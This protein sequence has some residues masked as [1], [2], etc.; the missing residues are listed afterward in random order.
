M[1]LLSG[2]PKIK[3]A[4]YLPSL[5]LHKNHTITN[6]I[7][8]YQIETRSAHQKLFNA[9]Q[10][11]HETRQHYLPKPGYLTPGITALEYYNRRFDLI[12]K[13]P[14]KSIAILTGNQIQYSSGSV[15]HE[16]QQDNDLYYMTGWLEP[17]SVAI[18][19]KR[20][21]NGDDEDMILHM[22]VPPRNPSVEIWEGERSG[23]QG[24]Y[25]FFNADLVEDINKIDNY[26]KE[27]IKRNHHVYW[28]DKINK[29][30]G[31]NNT[32]KFQTFFNNFSLNKIPITINEVLKSSSN[33]S[34]KPLHTLIAKQ[35][36]IKS[37]QEIKVLQKACQI[38]S[39]AINKAMAKVGSSS[40]IN[41]EKS[42]S[43]YLDYQFVKGGCD[44][45]A[46]IP[47]VA[48]GSNALII[49]YTR[50]DDLLY[51]NEMV[52]VDAGGKLGGYCAD[53]S[54]TWPNSPKGFSK[55]QK[56]IY[57]IVLKTNKLCI[58]KCYENNS[59]SI[60]DIH[61]IS[62]S[63]LTENIVK[64]P[65]FEKVTKN[66][67]SRYLYPHYIGHHLGLDLHDIPS[68]SRFQKLKAGNVITIEP[69]L[70]IPI[71]DKWPKEYQGI[72]VRVEDDVVV[73]KT[74]DD[75]INLTSGCVKEV[76]DI[77]SLIKSGKVTTPGIEDELVEI[78]I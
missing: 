10:P 21:D 55:Y 48:S 12:S 53:I 3:G 44:R 77:E 14:N 17:D 2:L 63:S 61:E 46:Y 37:P 68:I 54:R 51:K 6:A 13:L 76:S 71:D 23:L 67:V 78:D 22:I 75:I 49:H 27:L 72:G 28:D 66:D 4:S 25:D 9:G 8:Y 74:K 47:V 60:N 32:S 52:F 31:I 65:G 64:I 30:N 45:Q 15:F 18:I 33:I 7:R 29:K 57:E 40:P 5:K 41:T 42:L 50:N 35:R 62:V 59:I 73:G 70:Y 16:F 20:L 34:I 19:E 58:E 24:A 36:A 69:G 43:K 39:R 38:S 11:T 26:I 56:E 1:V